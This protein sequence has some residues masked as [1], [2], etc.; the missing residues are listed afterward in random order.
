MVSINDDI[1]IGG[2][3]SGTDILGLG[4]SNIVHYNIKT[5]TLQAL[6]GGGVNGI[7][8]TIVASSEGKLFS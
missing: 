5:S 2:D 6:Q 3:F 7:V 8:N 1:Y 4:Y